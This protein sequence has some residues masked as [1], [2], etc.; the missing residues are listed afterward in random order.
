MA[1]WY[2]GLYNI[3]QYTSGKGFPVFDID[4][5]AVKDM[6]QHM[7]STVALTLTRK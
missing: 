2:S 4:R 6:G 3:L 5:S 1:E 7:T